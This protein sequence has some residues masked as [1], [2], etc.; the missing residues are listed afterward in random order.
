MKQTHN[1]IEKFRLITDMTKLTDYYI[2][3]GIIFNFE[4]FS[5]EQVDKIP[6]FMTSLKIVNGHLCST[7]GINLHVNITYL[8]L[9]GNYLRDVDLK[10]LVNLEYLDLSANYLQ[11]LDSISGNK[12]IKTLNLMFNEIKNVDFVATL[13]QLKEFNIE[14][15]MVQ[16]LQPI[17]NHPNFCPQWD[18][19][20]RGNVV[21]EKVRIQ[22]NAWYSHNMAEKYSCQLEEKDGFKY[23]NITNDQ[24]LIQT[25]F[26]DYLKKLKPQEKYIDS[27]IEIKLDKLF[28]YEC[29]NIAFMT[30]SQYLKQLWICNSN[31]NSLGGI[32]KMY[33]LNNITFRQCG[34]FWIQEQLELTELPYL[35][36]LDVSQNGLDKF[37]FVCN[38]Q[39]TSLNV[40]Q[41]NLKSLAGIQDLLSLIILDVSG[42]TLE[43]VSELEYLKDLTELNISFNAIDSIQCL[44]Y[45]QKLGYFNLISNKVIDIE[46]CMKMKNLIDL[47]THRN[48]IQ[49][50]YILAEHPNVIES[51]L[52]EQLEVDENDPQV[53]RLQQL[54]KNKNVLDKYKNM[55]LNSSLQINNDQ[56]VKSFKFTD[57]IGVTNELSISQCQNVIFEVVPVLVQNLKVNSSGLQNIFGL[58]QMTPLTSLDLSDNQLEDVL[59]IQEL[60]KLTRLVLSNNRLSRLHWIKALT[61]LSYLDIQNNKFVSV[62]CLKDV[63]SLEELFI[64]GNMIQDADYLKQLQ[65]YNEKW[66]SPQK[67]FTTED[68]E[69][70]LGPN[71]TQQMVN[72]CVVKFNST[73]IYMS[74][75]LKNKSNVVDQN[76]V[77]KYDNDDI[78][79]SFVS[80]M[81]NLLDKKI[82][83]ISVENCPKLQCSVFH[84]I[85]SLTITNC[86]LNNIRNLTSSLINI[87][88]GFN[89]LK[90]VTELGELYNLQKLV[91]R[92]NKI[93]NLDCLKALFKL[94]Y[95]DVRN[96]KL[97]QINFIKHLPLLSEL[98]IDGNTICDL[99]CVV[100]DPKCQNSIAIQ[101]NPAF[102]TDSIDVLDYL[103]CTKQ[104]S[105]D[106]KVLLHLWIYSVAQRMKQ[107]D[108]IPQY[109]NL[110]QTIDKYKN[111]IEPKIWIFVQNLPDLEQVDCPYE[112]FGNLFR[113]ICETTDCE[114]VLQEIKQ[115]NP[116]LNIEVKEFRQLLLQ[117]D[118]EIKNI[119]F[120]NQL[121]IQSL[122]INKCINIK[123]NG[124][125]DIK[126]LQVNNCELQTFDGLQNWSQLL[127]L[128]LCANKLKNLEKL[129]NLTNLIILALHSNEISNLE[130]LK[131]L[132][133]LQQLHIKYNQIE[134]LE[135]LKTLQNLRVLFLDYNKIRNLEPI[136]GLVNL[137]VLYLSNNRIQ[138]LDYLK[139][140]INLVKLNLSDNQIENLDPLKNFVNLR[141]LYLSNNQ[142]NNIDSIQYLINLSDLYL[143]LNQ[144]QNINPLKGL[145]NLRALSLWRNY[146]ENLDPIKELLNLQ[147]LYLSEN[148]I[149]NLDPLTQLV[150]LKILYLSTNQIQNINSLKNLVNLTELYLYSNQISNIDSVK[151]L[152]NL[153]TLSLSANQIQNV[154]P[155]KQLI[156]LKDLSLS[157]NIIKNI[158]SLKYLVNL[159]ELDLQY[160]KIQ[161]YKPL[162]IHPNFKNYKIHRQDE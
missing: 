31:I 44:H 129:E 125:A 141:T 5:S 38:K 81:C 134:N 40:S 138:P 26:V 146:I 142:I 127:E 21:E 145:L 42:N 77:I 27:E 50:Q 79:L 130:P 63:Q 10:F 136:K 124:I 53:Q 153:Q 158:D 6:N 156:N 65:H 66:I 106:F 45:L 113:F 19:Y 43:S 115:I 20:Q 100:N 90:N 94:A 150:N 46:V 128:N 8:D 119:S 116:L 107:R 47:R 162:F 137:E 88:L 15:N 84:R 52:S 97:M 69:Y 140:L 132:V 161:N 111:K 139:N 56:Y 54:Q 122:I 23:L 30:N 160:N 72:D 154:N 114:K 95:V 36:Y 49:N 74:I 118:K 121:N 152:K 131:K 149:K 96:N 101:N 102:D 37:Q 64:Q 51:W 104:L 148:R 85:K 39:L 147:L 32:L 83:S 14:E 24:D 86:K 41:N 33:Q 62:E 108:E 29:N 17:Y 9:H 57:F 67:D 99:L 60:T 103:E 35:S 55:V 120:V 78:D 34:L 7:L 92:N 22:V 48:F 157:K 91:L 25:H 2:R 117:N 135:P 12:K 1:K 82:Y 76:L 159:V 61:Q 16:D 98:F 73:K 4:D 13:P 28:L 11:E 155:L 109:K 70:Y 112:F 3:E 89:D 87:D 126:L 133:N 143:Q 71:S 58:E 18:Q 110:V 75:A 123:F 151:N 105:T 80:F 59:E 144:I 93:Q 68:V